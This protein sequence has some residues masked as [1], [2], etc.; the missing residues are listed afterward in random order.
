LVRGDETILVLVKILEAL[1]QTFALQTLHQL[2]KLIV[3]EDM[4]SIALS[5]VEFDP[6]AV[7]GMSDLALYQFAHF[8]PV[9]VERNTVRPNVL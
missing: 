7:G 9:E 4:G 5:E 2:S 6:I 3:C 8:L 1:P